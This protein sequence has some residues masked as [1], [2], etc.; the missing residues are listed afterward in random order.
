MASMKQSSILQG[1]AQKGSVLQV[2]STTLT[3]TYSES[4]ASGVISSSVVTGLTA[5]IT[6]VSTSSKVLVQVST[7]LSNSGKLGVG[8]FL[9]RRG[10]TPIAQAT[11]ASN[12]S[13]VSMSG[14]AQSN[15]SVDMAALSQTFLDS[16]SS[17][18][19]IVYGISLHNTDSGTAN[20][21]VNR[22]D[23]D[24]DVSRTSR[25]VSTI[26]LMEVAG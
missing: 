12:R 16:P 24:V 10:T 23:A 1:V 2:V 8:A 26:T 17:T 6:P 5:A 4:V 13:R 21:Y 3:S 9:I 15:N 25:P 22:G 18:S 7:A 19:E 14:G 11:T 20:V